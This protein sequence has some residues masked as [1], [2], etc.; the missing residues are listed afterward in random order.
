MTRWNALPEKKKESKYHAHRVIED[1][2]TFDNMKE[3]RRYRELLILEKMGQ[4]KDLE[5]QKKYLI[6]PECRESSPAG[7]RG[8]IR[9]GRII[10]RAAYYVADFV[11][12][13]LDP[14]T[15][16]WNEVVEDVKGLRTDT[17]ILKRK[18][19]LYMHGIR[20]RET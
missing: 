10:E 1:G 16:E 8:G 5:R 20:I 4:V 11:Y 15:N 17:Y 9:I 2:Q 7:P 18:L 19:M 6:I 3:L 13:E 12:R 14:E